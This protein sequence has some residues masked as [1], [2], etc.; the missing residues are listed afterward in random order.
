[1]KNLPLGIHTFSKIIREN[2]LYVDKTKEIHRL[3]NEGVKYYF[4]SR[5][6]RFGKSLL[7]STLIELFSGNKELFKDLWIYDRWDWT[8]HPIIHLDFLGLKNSGKE[9]LIESLEYL[10]DLNAN[11]YEIQ[12]KEIGYDK[13]FKEL[14]AQLSK[15]ERVVI[16][17]DEYDKPII[18]NLD[19]QST[20]LENRKVLRTF[21]ETIK[22]SDRYLRF[23]FITGV[24]KFSK[25]SIFS[26]L[27]NLT[28]LTLSSKAPTLLGYTESELHR[29]FSGRILK[30]AQKL[31]IDEKL[32]LSEIKQW[33]N[34]Y[35]WD[36]VH[37]VYNPFSILSLFSENTFGNFWFTTGT[38]AFLLQVIKQYNVD[39]DELENYSTDASIF[40]SYDV[41]RMNPHS[42]LFQTGYL[43]IREVENISITQRRYRLSYPNMEVK[44]S[45][46][47][48]VLADLSGRFPNETANTI[49]TLGNKIKENDLDGFFTGLKALF[50][51]IPSHIFPGDRESYYHTV[52]Y[53]V[54][55]LLGINIAAEVHTNKGRIDAVIETEQHV[56]VIEFKMGTSTEALAQIQNMKYHERFL[57][58]GK[59]ITLIGAG[60][61]KEEKNISDYQLKPLI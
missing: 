35:S 15:K 54:L 48:Y 61:D 10:V 4:L 58:S 50:A 53:L 14:V 2:Y 46:L 25:V 55:T 13:R 44:E 21:Y 30:M 56:Y 33:Y 20:A 26:G 32:L 22:E 38:P 5:P 43:T 52:I 16:L 37:F 41:D 27:N 57:S 18:D 42:L 40:D 45:F 7:V 28:D 24:S 8:S 34:G 31:A 1:M 11:K 60:F 19:N 23:A 36:G 3:L 6:R 51:S 59:S 29:Y 9:E 17:A 47:K 49:F 39:I 12:L